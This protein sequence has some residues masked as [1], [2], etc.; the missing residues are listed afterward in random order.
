[1]TFFPKLHLIKNML[2]QWFPKG[3]K[4]PIIE[5]ILW[6]SPDEDYVYTMN[7]DAPH[8]PQRR[9]TEDIRNAH[10]EFEVTLLS[11]DNY[12]EE[13]LTLSEHLTEKQQA[14]I[15]EM[16]PVINEITTAENGEAIFIPQK[17]ARLLKESAYSYKKLRR[18]LFTYWRLGQVPVAL[19][20]NYH[21][22]G[23]GKRHQK[24]NQN[25][26][27]RAPH[28]TCAITPEV[29]HRMHRGY[30]EFFVKKRAPSVRAAYQKTIEKYFNDGYRQEDNG[31]RTPIL[32][33][34]NE[35]PSYMQFWR[36]C[37][38]TRD[39]EKVAKAREGETRTQLNLAPKKGSANLMAFGPGAWFF[40]D[41]TPAD[42]QLVSSI[43]RS[44]LI[45]KPTLYFV[46]DLFSMMIV[47]YAL[48]LEEP[49]WMSQILALVNAATP[50][51]D[52]CA[53]YG[54]SIKE[55]QWPCH[56]LPQF[57]LGDRGELASHQGINL[58]QN[59]NV[60]VSN[61]PPYMP[62]MKGPVELAFNQANTYVLHDVPGGGHPP[63]RAQRDNRGVPCLTLYEAHQIIIH[64]ILGFNA[65]H[66]QKEYAPP[67]KFMMGDQVPFVPL[68][69]WN[70]GIENRSGL[71]RRFPPKVVYKSLLKREQGSISP[72]GIRF[73][74]RRFEVSDENL[75]EEEREWL[76]AA[77][78]GRKKVEI[79]Y[80]PRL[81]NTIFLCLPDQRFITCKLLDRE[82]AFLDLS[83][84]ESEQW[85]RL[86]MEQQ[87]QLKQQWL[88]ALAVVNAH[89]NEIIRKAELEA[90]AQREAAGISKNGL[91]QNIQ[92]Y[93]KAEKLLNRLLAEENLRSW[94]TESPQESEP[95]DPGEPNIMQRTDSR[96]DAVISEMVDKQ[97]GEEESDDNNK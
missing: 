59:L 1:M 53:E 30:N 21:Q 17:R 11:N 49:S 19:A 32:K 78:T 80:D 57:L 72:Q 7:V 69:L 94:F 44:W 62:V 37:H 66:L 71:L 18:A 35:R 76:F 29:A 54:I 75:T 8:M 22:R 28:K 23:R 55:E 42:I 89:V 48:T 93:R 5:R 3:D 91:F 73:K 85:N 20:P 52:Y 74:K 13:C 47:G 88:Q 16:W 87:R 40:I 67:D 77:R 34:P 68:S 36:Q 12:M 50:K 84:A 90:L 64:Y 83:W 96:Y 25:A 9:E 24:E 38:A 82:R 81:I 46:Q 41:S 33:K 92:I 86:D 6:I 31:V 51:K 10:R 63:Q 95:I 58:V 97:Q 43:N 79:A 65:A 26:L 2:I 61:N 27:G 60:S 56:F 70:W 15:D 14:V 4:N 39:L 45:G